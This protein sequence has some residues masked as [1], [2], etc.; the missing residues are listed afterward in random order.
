MDFGSINW[1]AVLVCVIVSM[2][3]GSL[4][5]NPKTFFPVWW[6]GIGKS[7]NDVPGGGGG[8]GMTWALT[9]LASFIQAV[10]MSLMVTAMGSMTPGGATLVSGATA[11][12]ILWL[13]FVAPTSLVNKLFAGHGL[14]IW[15]IEAGNHL[16]TFV[17]FGAILGAWR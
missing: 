10:F 13:G 7:E 5:F 3:V 11:G 9:V 8:M 15:A 16:V 17:V 4:W 12:A 2:L 1:L 6:K 14:K